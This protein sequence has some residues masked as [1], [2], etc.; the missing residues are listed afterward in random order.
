MFIQPPVLL[1]LASISRLPVRQGSATDSALEWETGDPEMGLQLPEA[2]QG[3]G[4][5]YNVWA[6][7]LCPWCALADPD[8]LPYSHAAEAREVMRSCACCGVAHSI[9]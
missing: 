7:R 6:Q 5:C 9:V 1:C 4:A 2:T 3:F 8:P